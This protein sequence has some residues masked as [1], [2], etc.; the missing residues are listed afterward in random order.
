[1]GGRTLGLQILEHRLASG[2][3]YVR[4]GSQPAIGR[5][6]AAVWPGRPTSRKNCQRI[7]AISCTPTASVIGKAEVLRLYRK[8]RNSVGKCVSDCPINERR[9]FGKLQIKI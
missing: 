8:S 7:A 2:E 1:M 9:P 6:V 5:Q 4:I 3:R